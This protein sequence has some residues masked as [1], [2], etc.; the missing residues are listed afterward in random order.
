MKNTNTT[1][2]DKLLAALRSRPA[3][4]E[5][6]LKSWGRE[7]RPQL[8]GSQAEA[9]ADALV[10]DGLATRETRRNGDY[11]WRAITTSEAS[12]FAPPEEPA[13]VIDAA[14][15]VAGDAEPCQGCQV[16]AHE[17]ARVQ[18]WLKEARDSR[19]AARIERDEAR[20]QLDTTR[21]EAHGLRQQLQEVSAERDEARARCAAWEQEADHAYRQLCRAA[22][23]EEGCPLSSI[24]ERVRLLVAGAQASAEHTTNQGDSQAPPVDPGAIA[25]YLLD[26]PE[27]RWTGLAQARKDLAQ[28]RRLTEHGARLQAEA[29]AAVDRLLDTSAGTPAAKPAKAP[30]EPARKRAVRTGEEPPANTLLGQTLALVRAGKAHDRHSVAKALGRSPDAAHSDLRTLEARGLLERTGPG[31]WVAVGAGKAAAQ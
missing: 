7:Q 20:E 9:L 22:D 18:A 12:A 4:G 29:L 15:M 11:V 31:H 16:S 3:M 27:E 8:T 14:A 19:D 6:S 5:Q 30:S 10:S 1:T 25:H 13:A 17:M 21:C 28:G 24:L 26:L 23:L 2:R